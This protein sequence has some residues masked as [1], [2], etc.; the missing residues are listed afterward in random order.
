MLD[1]MEIVTVADVFGAAIQNTKVN[2]LV[3]YLNFKRSV[4]NMGTSYYEL[5]IKNRSLIKK[6]G[7]KSLRRR[8]DPRCFVF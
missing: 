7:A 1:N 4:E 6:K 3:H 2:Q 5:K 8:I